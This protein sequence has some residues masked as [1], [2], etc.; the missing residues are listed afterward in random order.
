MFR[1]K[2]GGGCTALGSESPAARE[3]AQSRKASCRVPCP[4]LPHP[5]ASPAPAL[6]PPQLHCPPA[7]DHATP[8]SAGGGATTPGAAPA[9]GRGGL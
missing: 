5:S 1:V 9:G 7:S 6:P 8:R 4:P 3:H 2:Q